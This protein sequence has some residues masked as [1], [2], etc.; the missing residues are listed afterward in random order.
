MPTVRGGGTAPVGEQPTVSE[1]E[2]AERIVR[3]ELAC[4]LEEAKGMRARLVLMEALLPA[5]P[6]ESG[7]EDLEAHPKGIAALRIELQGLIKDH[8]GPLLAELVAMD[9][10]RRLAE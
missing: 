6:D 5:T 10:G 9:E 1:A 8:L 3:Q 7:T 4:I 2:R